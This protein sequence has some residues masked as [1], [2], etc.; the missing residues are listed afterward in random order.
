MVMKMLYEAGLIHGKCL[1]VTGMTVAENL[2]YA[3]ARPKNQ[4]IIYSLEKPIAPAG[5]HIVI[6]KGDMAS[7]GAVMKLSGKMMKQHKGPARVFESEDMAM[8][9]ILDGKIKHGDVIIIRFEGPK[10]GPGMREMLSPSSALVGAGLGKDVALITDGR[11]SGGTHGIMVGHVA[12]EAAVGGP[13]GLVS[14]GDIID[15]DV[16]KREINILVDK[17]EMEKRKKKWKKPES[18]YKRGVLAK[19]ARLVGS[20]SKGAVTS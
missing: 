19:Y 1:T 12:P 8:A 15:I 4:D 5:H 7:E 20:A 2:E 18:K 9:A 6:M 11:F 3:D 17:K 14:E 13:I 10:G 16:A